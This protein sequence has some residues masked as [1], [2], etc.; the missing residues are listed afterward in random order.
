MTE[1]SGQE[2]LLSTVNVS[3]VLL[4][5]VNV[6]TVGTGNVVLCYVRVDFPV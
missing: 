4:S 3:T 2:D 6:S 5:T 1:Y